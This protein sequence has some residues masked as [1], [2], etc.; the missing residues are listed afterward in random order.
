LGSEEGAGAR[1]LHDIP[2]ARVLEAVERVLYPAADDA[3]YI[4]SR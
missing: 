1:A 3:R 4:S 2:V